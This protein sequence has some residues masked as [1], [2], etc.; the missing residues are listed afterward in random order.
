MRMGTH[1][2]HGSWG[3][4]RDRQTERERKRG[5]FAYNEL[6]YVHSCTRCPE[7]FEMH[8]LQAEPW[9][10]APP[11]AQDHSSLASVY[12]S[13][14]FAS[15]PSCRLSDPQRTPTIYSRYWLRL[16]AWSIDP[17]T[18]TI[19]ENSPSFVR[20]STQS[21]SRFFS[22]FLWDFSSKSRDICQYAV[23]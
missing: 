15:F 14:F 23:I 9:S 17:S 11:H 21:I 2:V 1:K 16:D 22:R 13:L 20:E 5:A 19:W 10:R 6:N 4:P 12:A 18:P 8:S 3:Q 7:I